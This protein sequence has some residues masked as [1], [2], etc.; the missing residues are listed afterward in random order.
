MRNQTVEVALRFY[1]TTATDDWTAISSYLQ[2]I[3]NDAKNQSTGVSP[4]EVLD[5]FS[6][7]DTMHVLSEMHP[8]DFTRLRQLKRDQAEES[9]AFAKAMAKHNY[10]RSHKAIELQEGPQVFLRL[11]YGY[12]IPGINPKLHH[13]RIEP[14]SVL[15]KEVKF[16]NKLDL[17]PTMKIHPVISISQLE[18][19]SA[20]HPDPY[21]HLRNRERPAVLE[22]VEVHY[23]IEKLLN[24]RVS[25]GRFNI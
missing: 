24:K 17:P 2:G 4:N 16:A 13:Q 23:D 25:R 6:V 15:E 20:P 3:L 21:E 7:Q 5:G 1:L 10:D 18:P 22:L 14:F 11:H 12:R 19:I 8:E 9:L